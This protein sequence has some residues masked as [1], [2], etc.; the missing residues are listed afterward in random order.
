MQYASNDLT[1]HERYKVLTAFIL[2]RPIAWV[3]R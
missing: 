3:P 1:A 2:P